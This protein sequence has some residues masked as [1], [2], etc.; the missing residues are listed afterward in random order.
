MLTKT[1][2]KDFIDDMTCEEKEG[3]P[4]ISFLA[5]GLFGMHTGTCME[6]KLQG[7]MYVY[8]VRR[9][10]EWKEGCVDEAKAWTKHQENDF[11]SK[12]SGQ[13][14]SY[15]R[16]MSRRFLYHQHIYMFEQMKATSKRN[17]S[18]AQARPRSPGQVP[19]YCTPSRLH[20]TLV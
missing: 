10:V 20:S 7:C 12:I 14:H 13:M 19:R 2:Q 15:C 5:S 1:S 11:R 4:N 8:C 6:P 3:L 17:R 16:K 9:R 18:P